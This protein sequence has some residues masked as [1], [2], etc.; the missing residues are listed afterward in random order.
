MTEVSIAVAV[1]AG[2]LSFLSP[3]VLALLPVYLAFLGEAAAEGGPGA[4]MPARAV[5]LPQALL[6]VAGFGY[7][8]SNTHATSRLQLGVE[9]WERGRIMALWSVAFLGARP[10]ASLVDGALAERFGVRLAAAA[11]AT[12]VLIAAGILLR[13]PSKRAERDPEPVRG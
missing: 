2:T 10:F 3:C 11:L 9:P 4:S 13:S 5:V 12:P 7:L 1:A 6:F 8:A